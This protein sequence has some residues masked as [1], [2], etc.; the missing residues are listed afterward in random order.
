MIAQSPIAIR[1]WPDT[2]PDE[3]HTLGWPILAWTADYLTQPDGPHYGEPWEFTPEQVRI[4]L[5]WYAIDD[6]G[7]FLYHRG[8]LRRMKGWGK[9]P[10]LAVLSCVELCGPC[11]FG[12]WNKDGTPRVIPHSSPWIQVAAVSKDQTR[13]T[14]TLFPGLFTPQAK[15]EYSL[16]IGKEII[17]SKIGKNVGRIEAVTSSPRSLEGSRPSLVVLN[18]TQHWLPSNEGPE[19]EAAIRRNLGKSRDGAARAMEITNAHLMGELSVAEQTYEAWRATDGALA[20]VYYDS[21]EAPPLPDLQDREAVRSGLIAARGDS[22]W[23]DVDR[24]GIEIADPTTTESLARRY[25]FNQVWDVKDQQW[26]LDEIWDGRR[27]PGRRAPS[28]IPDGLDVMVG[29]DGSFNDDSTGV[30]VASCGS[31]PHLEVVGCWEKPDDPEWRVPILE[32]EDKLREVC[33]RWR[34]RELIFDPYRWARTMQVLQ[35]E[36]L[37]V[38]EY[39]QSPDRMVPAAARF[40]EATLNGTLTHDGDPRLARHISNVVIREGSRGVRIVK[41]TKWSPRK[42]DLAVAA[43]MAHDRAASRATPGFG[44]MMAWRAESDR[45]AL[46]SSRPGSDSGSVPPASPPVAATPSPR[47]FFGDA[48][49]ANSPNTCQHRWFAGFCAKCAIPYGEQS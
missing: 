2:V 6:E 36:G 23:V 1:T 39:P 20:G 27:A 15:Q 40:L 16:E 44:W 12:G 45:A 21:I 33:R 9:D 35:R 42:I 37:P 17:Y 10:F 28:V 38:V 14:M 32:V 13:N 5:R 24:V 47:A 8:V 19:M 3:K 30:V 41:E 26:I 29:I 49:K 31:S 4:L 46:P 48:P 7:R 18:E 25:Y 22:L 11:R 34:V 43:V